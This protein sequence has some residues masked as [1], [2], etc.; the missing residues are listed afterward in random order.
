[1]NTTDIHATDSD[2]RHAG[3]IDPCHYAGRTLLG[4]SIGILSQPALRTTDVE[5]DL[6][7]IEKLFRVVLEMEYML[8][9][10]GGLAH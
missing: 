5:E 6:V 2:D 1:M 8:W 9:I 3:P 10:P 7:R 4:C